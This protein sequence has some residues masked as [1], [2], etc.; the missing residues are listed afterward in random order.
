[1]V[2]SGIAQLGCKA[3]YLGCGVDGS[4]GQSRR[5]T[6]NLGDAKGERMHVR[7]SFRESGIGL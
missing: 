7:L 4:D 5:G 2:D 1:V 3:G 6:E